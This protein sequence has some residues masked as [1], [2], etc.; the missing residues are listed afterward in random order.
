M[1]GD[2]CQ[3]HMKFS[4]TDFTDKPVVAL[5]WEM[6]KNYNANTDENFY[7]EMNEEKIMK[8]CEISIIYMPSE[9]VNL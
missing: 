7:Y 3:T 4:K 5:L 6:N 2:D 1:G 9:V 8:K